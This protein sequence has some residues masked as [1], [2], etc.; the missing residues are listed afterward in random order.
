MRKILIIGMGTGNPEHITIQA[1]NALQQVNVLFITDKGRD[2][3]ELARLRREICAR[4]VPDSRH[5]TIEITDPARDRN[6]SDYRAAVDTWHQQRANLYEELI[7]EHVGA[8]ECG[9]FLVWGDPSLYD[10]TTRIIGQIAARASVAFE[11]EVIPGITSI[12]ALTARH[13][14][15]L[16]QVGE[17]V[18]ITTGRRL[19]EDS[20]GSASDVVVM[21]D[22]DCAFKTVA[23]DDGIEIYW[24]AYLGTPDE[25][26]LAGKLSD[27]AASIQRLRGE[28]RQRKGWIMD[29]YLL[30]KPARERPS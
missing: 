6:P 26:L 3:E 13:G 8:D 24:G 18:Q 1:V 21:L 27:C 28:A 15:P 7:A 17:P 12:Q 29:T 19:A 4:Y 25:I 16:N 14:I 5:R 23:D 2:K 30:R 22:G 20:M 9:A 11:Y 10:S